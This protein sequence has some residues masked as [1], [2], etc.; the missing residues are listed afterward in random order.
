MTRL[1][2]PGLCLLV[3]AYCSLCEAMHAHA[4]ALALATGRPLQVLDVDADPALEA[5]WG[6]AVPVLFLGPPDER[7]ELCRYHWDAQRVAT[8]VP[9]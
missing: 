4:A 9:P 2:A 1:P 8:A 7:N 6:D 3:R 5:A